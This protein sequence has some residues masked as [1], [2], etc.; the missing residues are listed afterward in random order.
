MQQTTTAARGSE[1]GPLVAAARNGDADAWRALLARYT[2]M[3][4][5]KC[6]SYRLSAEDASDV[7]QTT[8]LLAVQ[9]LGQLR[10][11][12][13]VGGWLATIAERECLK[14]VRRRT[15]ETV[16][17]D[18]GE[19]DL[20]GRRTPSPE[21]EVARSWLTGI[22]PTL[23]GQLSASQQVLF[24]ALTGLPEAH[25]AD[26]ARLTGR[27]VGSIGPSRARCLARLRV[28][29]EDREVDAGFLN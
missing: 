13:H 29:L 7:V 10:S 20:P 21:R 27:P 22:L 16:S 14:V 23:V 15:R 4:R 2:G 9:H 24:K 12:D 17:D 26:V 18:L 11:D 25:Y 3:L 1:V 19:I 28:M 5:V 6:R 8:W